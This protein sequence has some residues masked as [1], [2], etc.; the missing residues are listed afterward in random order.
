MTGSD[1][2]RDYARKG[3][4]AWEAAA[5]ELARQGQLVPWPY[6]DV[7]VTDGTNSAILKVASDVL[8]VG[9]LEDH[10]RLPLMPIMAQ[11]ILNLSGALLPTPLLEYRIWQQAPLK[12]HPTGQVPNRGGD[13]EQYTQHSRVI[14]AELAAFGGAQGRL[15]SGHKKA[16]LIANFYRPIKV[17]IGGWYRPPPAPDV[18]DDRRSMSAVDRQPVQPRSNVHGEGYV[19]YSHGIR[20]V[21]PVAIVNGQAMA[22]EDLYRH[23]T[24]SR[25]VSDEGPLKIVRYPGARVPVAAIRPPSSADPR[26]AAVDVIPRAPLQ[27]GMIDVGLASIAQQW[28]R[29]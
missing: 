12:L 20:A 9:T 14:D 24:L 3:P 4:T 19:D 26:D 15:V 28:N 8:S 13:L 25:L 18:I 11:N 5:L 29:R 1:F 21:G 22:T 6:V 2:V 10:V 16:V 7:A 23:P 17:L 27:P